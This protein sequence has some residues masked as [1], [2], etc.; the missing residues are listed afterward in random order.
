[1]GMANASSHQRNARCRV[2]KS[3]TVASICAAALLSGCGAAH[4]WPMRAEVERVIDGDTVEARLPSGGTR[5]VRVVGIDAPESDACYGR[6][7]TRYARETLAGETVTLRRPADPHDDPYGRLLAHI[8]THGR[9]WARGMVARGYARV[10]T[11]PPNDGYAVELRAV[12]RDARQ[13]G[14]GMWGE[15]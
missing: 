5:D 7:A 8:V 4:D 13:A 15:C 9:L 2:R 14:A 6:A 11:F 1:M 12:Q 10:A 3:A